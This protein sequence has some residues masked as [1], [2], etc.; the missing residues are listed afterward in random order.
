MLQAGC[1]VRVLHP[2]GETYAGQ[3]VVVS[4]NADGVVFLEGIDGGFDPMYLEVV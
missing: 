3:Y 1:I 2:F 4:V